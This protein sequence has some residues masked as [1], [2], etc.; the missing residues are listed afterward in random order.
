MVTISASANTNYCIC[1][2]HSKKNV[3]KLKKLLAL[4]ACL[5]AF[6]FTSCKKDNPAAELNPQ[7]ITVVPLSAVPSAVVASFNNSFTNA[8][9]VEWHKINDHFEV[10]F[11]HQSQRHHCGF[12]NNGQQ[13]SH[14]I[15]CTNAVVPAAVL[16]AFRSRNPNDNVYEWNQRTD[17][18]WKAQPAHQRFSTR[19]HALATDLNLV[20]QLKLVNHQRTAHLFFKRIVGFHASLHGR[21][22]ET[23]SI[24]PSCLGLV[25]RDIRLFEQVVHDVVIP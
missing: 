10:E 20:M 2:Y 15:S 14:T 12:D 4:S 3:M 1:N 21:I 19:R 18:T 13:S 11:N 24:S 23:N 6:V 17:G 16:N 22:K 9:E 25:H 5:V 8:T 7:S